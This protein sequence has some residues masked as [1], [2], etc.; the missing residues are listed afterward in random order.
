MPHNLGP[1]AEALVGVANSSPSALARVGAINALSG[2][3]S[4]A[5]SNSLASLLTNSDENIR[6]SAVK[7]LPRFPLKFAERALRERWNAMIHRL[8]A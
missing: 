8:S 5:V 4:D 7:L 6:L 1:F 3:K 2:L